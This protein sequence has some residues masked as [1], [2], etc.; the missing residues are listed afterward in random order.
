MD[1][2][3]LRPALPPPERCRQARESPRVAEPPQQTLVLLQPLAVQIGGADCV[4][5]C[6]Q[7]CNKKDLELCNGPNGYSVSV[8]DWLSRNPSIL[9]ECSLTSQYNISYLVLQSFKWW[10]EWRVIIPVVYK[11]LFQALGLP[12]VFNCNPSSFSSFSWMYSSWKCQE[13][14][15]KK[16]KQI[17]KSVAAKRFIFFGVKR[18][19]EKIPMSLSVRRRHGIQ[20]YLFAWG[21]KIC[22]VFNIFQLDI[23]RP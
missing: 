14:L 13:Q 7:I 19:S 21:V 2:L 9:K 17:K 10:L 23:G 18:Q 16:Q 5:V 20:P 12:L 1:F 11:G 4:D 6:G 22:C 3:C 8:S 15:R